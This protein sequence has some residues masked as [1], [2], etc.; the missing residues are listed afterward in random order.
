MRDLE[1]SVYKMSDSQLK[2]HHMW[3]DTA[4]DFHILI[5]FFS[6]RFQLFALDTH[7]TFATG[8][9]EV[10]SAFIKHSLLLHCILVAFSFESPCM[11]AW[12]CSSISVSDTVH[13]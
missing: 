8:S 7:S 11:F 9:F 12:L 3:I 13:R 1:L 2:G 4:T 5:M 6:H 10:H